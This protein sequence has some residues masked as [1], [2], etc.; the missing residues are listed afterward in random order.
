MN[1]LPSGPLTRDEAIALLR[2]GDSPLATSAKSIRGVQY[3]VFTHAPN[4][5]RDFFTFSNKHFA[6]REFLV[7]GDERMT[8]G[9]VHAR[10]IALCKALRAREVQPGDHVAIAMQCLQ[11]RATRWLQESQSIAH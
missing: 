3:D 1:P 7:Y 11:Q 4:D 9:E 6:E 8:F 5:L 10:T 2:S